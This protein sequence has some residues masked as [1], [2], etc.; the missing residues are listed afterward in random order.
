MTRPGLGIAD[1]AY[2]APGELLFHYTRA[3]TAFEHILPDCKIRLSPYELM[4][5]PLEA[6]HWPEPPAYWV[7]PANERQDE[8]ELARLGVVIQAKSAARLLSL[9]ADSDNHG[10]DTEPFGRGYARASMW[11]F[12]RRGSPRRL[13]RVRP[14]TAHCDLDAR[15]F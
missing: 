13:P 8:L 15:T 6:R 14:R 1:G 9:T 3:A 10:D 5:D 11:Q 4:R 12:Y 7:D 2:G